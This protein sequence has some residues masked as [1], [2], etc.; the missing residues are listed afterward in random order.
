M[1]YKMLFLLILIAPMFVNGMCS[2]QCNISAHTTLIPR[3][4]SQNS[5]L[6]LALHNY[7]QYHLPVCD[8]N[9]FPWFNIELTAP[10]Y[11]KSAKPKH[12][13]SYFLPQ[14]NN[15]LTVAT[16]NTSDISSFWLEIATGNPAEP[17]SSK[18]CIEPSREVIGGAVRLFFDLSSC[19]EDCDCLC[20]N[21]WLSIFIPIQQVRHN[22]HL[23]EFPDSIPGIM[24]GFANVIS[25]LNNPAWNF[26]KWSPKS[27]KKWGVDDICIKIGC[28]F[29]QETNNH[30][31][32]YGLIFAPTGH[33]TKARYLFEPLV[34]SNHVGL[35]LGLNADYRA[36][37]C[38]NRS[39]DLMIDARYAYYLKHE[40]IRSIDLFNGDLSRYLLV[41]SPTNTQVPLPGIN[42]FTQEVK[43]TPGSM[44]ELWAAVNFSSC[45]WQIEVGYDFWFRAR[46]KIKLKNL[47]LGIGVFDIAAGLPPCPL[48]A[49][50][51]RIC[52]A[53]NGEADAP[54][55]D[56]TFISVKN[57]STINR[58]ILQNGTQSCPTLCA[59][60]NQCSFL[61]LKSAAN[62]HASSSTFY[63]A[64]AR[65]CCL[66]SN[67]VMFGIGGQYEIA[68][69][70]SALSQG[71]VWLKTAISF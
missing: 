10:Y 13:A 46:E 57:S 32:L 55:S 64:I 28:D 71:G 44:F 8:D 63:A 42:Y 29:I 49:H 65:Q 26:G 16:N 40:E 34:G 17:F 67:P 25:A 27:L 61:N 19:L 66:C 18:I 12:I 11:F 5:V 37:Q 39:V 45:N 2:T 6:E 59:L 24:P 38:E 9:C 31:G 20:P 68:H 33:G 3:K 62:P 36:Y 48:T 56:T 41:V 21:W 4:M 43:V 14:C 51:A 60:P 1:K 53:V 22:L 47:D 35:G 58:Q 54:V 70:K 30:L 23:R 15:C 52:Q 50:C 7:Y 69:R